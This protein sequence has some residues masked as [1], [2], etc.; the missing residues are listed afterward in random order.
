MMSD[1]PQMPAILNI[2]ASFFGIVLG[3]AG[4]GGCWRVASRLWSLP[5]AVGEGIVAIAVIVWA[6]LSAL[7]VG[8]WVWGRKAALTEFDHPIQCCFIGLMPVSTMLV[9][10]AILPYSY[11]GAAIIGAVGAVGQIAFA[12]YR[13]GLLW[14][15]GRA[16]TTTTPILYLPTVAGNLVTANLA[17]AL[18]IGDLAAMFFG[19]GVLAWLALESVLMHR[20]YTQEPMAMPLRPT[21]GIQ[22]APPVVAC[23]AYLSL[24]TGAPDLVAKGLLGY[25][26]L[27]ALILIRL[28]PW[29]MEGAFS[30]G[31]WAF[32]FGMTALSYDAMRMAE[33]GAGGGFEILAIV[34]FVLVNLGIAA[35]AIATL[36]L[37][38]ERRLL[39]P[40][41]AAVPTTPVRVV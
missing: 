28:L 13:T 9:G 24:T 16:Q 15:G 7:Y 36:R 27:L 20:L 2:P 11:V 18:G 5:A 1:K 34:L 23:S 21:L 33:R 26:I 32:T 31:Y 41:A 8:K 40:P 35:I 22:L 19:A 39:P 38:F 14:T 12:V 10:I 30:P 4:L 6:L 37:L 17:S 3:L 25:G 29:I